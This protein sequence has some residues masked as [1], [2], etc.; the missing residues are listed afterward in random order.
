MSWKKAGFQNW[1]YK[2]KKIC[3]FQESFVQVF[4]LF[5]RGKGNRGQAQIKEWIFKKSEW[6]EVSYKLTIS[7]NKMSKSC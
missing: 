6:K 4:T 2:S 7:R 1:N 5:N 3:A